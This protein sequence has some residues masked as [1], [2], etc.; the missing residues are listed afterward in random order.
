MAEG[1]DSNW[2]QQQ[3]LWWKRF[4]TV[5]RLFRGASTSPRF[6]KPRTKVDLFCFGF[7]LYEQSPVSHDVV[8]EPAS[9]AGIQLCSPRH[10]V[11]ALTYKR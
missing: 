6:H 10:A 9:R 1:K 4:L 7:T 5:A 2:C 3:Q 8:C 11:A